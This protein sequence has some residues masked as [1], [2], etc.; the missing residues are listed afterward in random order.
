MRLMRMWLLV[1]VVL[2]G[3]T[4]TLAFAQAPQELIIW[5]P[6]LEK[7]LVNGRPVSVERAVIKSDIHQVAKQLQTQW[8]NDEFPVK[9]DRSGEWLIVSR[10]FQG[11]IESAQIRQISADSSEILKHKTTLASATNEAKRS[12]ALPA[13]ITAD[14][15]V[16]FVTQSTDQGQRANT[17]LLATSLSPEAALNLLVGRFKAM[18]F[19][20][21]PTANRSFKDQSPSQGIQAV[22]A[23]SNGAHATVQVMISNVGT[24]VL[25][26]YKP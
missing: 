3:Q 25:V 1:S 5:R 22:M 15:S 26:L 11:Q 24:S 10:I 16:A 21:H 14:F 19:L 6:F 18:G 4:Q 9:V 2:W 12:E 17:Y 20:P 8:R 23:S 7:M 13:W